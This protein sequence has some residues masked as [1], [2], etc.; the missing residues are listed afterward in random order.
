EVLSRDVERE[1]QAE[2]GGRPDLIIGNYS[3]GNLVAILL[4]IRLGVTQCIIAHAVEKT[5]YL[6]SDI[7]WQEN[8]DK[9]HFSCQYTADLLA[10]N[11]ADFIVASTYQEIARTRQAEGQYES[12]RAF[13]MPALYRVVNGIDLFDPKFNIV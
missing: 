12:Y 1:A 4:S 3:D 6:H 13:S 7:Y 10:M 11:A 5:K 9:Y 8:E 2:F